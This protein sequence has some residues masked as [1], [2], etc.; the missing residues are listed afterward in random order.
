MVKAYKDIY[1]ELS[2]RK[3]LLHIS[4]DSLRRCDKCARN[5]RNNLLFCTVVYTAGNAKASMQSA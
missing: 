1:F 3:N 4:V 5:P 2:T